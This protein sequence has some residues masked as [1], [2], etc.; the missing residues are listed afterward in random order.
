MP[1]P[2]SSSTFKSYC[3]FLSVNRDGVMLLSFYLQ[4]WASSFTTHIS[5]VVLLGGADLVK[6]AEYELVSTDCAAQILLDLC[7]QYYT[8]KKKEK[9]QIAADG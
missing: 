6:L 4:D 2:P 3:G 7:A 9:L 8:G 1:L 5:N